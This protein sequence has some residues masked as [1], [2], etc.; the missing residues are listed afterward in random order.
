ETYPNLNGS[1]SQGIK[2]SK[3]LGWKIENSNSGYGP[4]PKIRDN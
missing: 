1:I 3:Y 2:M 4:P